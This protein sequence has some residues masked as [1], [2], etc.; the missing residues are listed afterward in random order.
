[1]PTCIWIFDTFVRS[2]KISNVSYSSSGYNLR[3]VLRL[4]GNSV[5]SGVP[6]PPRKEQL[7]L[8]CHLLAKYSKAL[9]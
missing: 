4:K 3:F 9:R 5:L 7:V 1:M 8:E 6:T 2:R